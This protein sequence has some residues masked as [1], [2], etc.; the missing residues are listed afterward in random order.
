MRMIRTK[1]EDPLFAHLAHDHVFKQL[2][3]REYMARVTCPVLLIHYVSQS[4]T[5]T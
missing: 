2:S 3:L 1:H 4:I 5:R